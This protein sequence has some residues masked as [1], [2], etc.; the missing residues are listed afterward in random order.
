MAASGLTRVEAAGFGQSGR[1]LIFGSGF[2]GG[3][4]RSL[5]RK[6]SVILAF[7]VLVTTSRKSASTVVLTAKRRITVHE[8]QMT[9]HSQTHFLSHS[10]AQQAT[11]FY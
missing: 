3:S 5:Y 6:A 1:P 2:F 4:V 8:S 11:C 9:H 10:S 7:D